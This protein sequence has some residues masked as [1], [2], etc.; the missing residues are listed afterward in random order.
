MVLT[1]ITWHVEDA[2]YVYTLLQ[3]LCA[4][5]AMVFQGRTR[6]MCSGRVTGTVWKVFA[7]TVQAVGEKFLYVACSDFSVFEDFA[8][9]GN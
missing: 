7:C 2:I 3:L 9:Q 4:V 8:S 6:L 1:L 5:F